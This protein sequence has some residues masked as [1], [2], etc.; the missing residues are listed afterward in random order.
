MKHNA[1]TV[2]PVPCQNHQQPIIWLKTVP[3][4]INRTSHSYDL[5]VIVNVAIQTG[6]V[7]CRLGCVAWRWR[8]QPKAASC[9]WRATAGQPLSPARMYP[10]G[11]IRY[12]RCLGSRRPNPRCWVC[13]CVCVVCECVCVCAWMWGVWAHVYARMNMD[14]CICVCV[15]VCEYLGARMWIWCF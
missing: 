10:L 6:P 13:V 8:L 2:S 15:Y 12:P 4:I 3:T 9:A 11:G 5:M 14:V 1:V 7:C